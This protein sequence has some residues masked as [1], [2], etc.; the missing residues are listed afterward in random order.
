MSCPVVLPCT[1]GPLL[2]HVRGCDSPSVATWLHA[3]S[4]YTSAGVIW[5]N[6]A[7]HSRT[8]TAAAI[9]MHLQ[10]P[11]LD[12]QDVDERELRGV[13]AVGLLGTLEE[14]GWQLREK[15]LTL[16]AGE[17]DLDV[18]TAGVGAREAGAL[19]AILYHTEQLEREFDK[20]PAAGVAAALA[21]AAGAPQAV[22]KAR[23]AEARAALEVAEKADKPKH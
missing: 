10:V 7:T 12:D 14:V 6:V 19:T 23:A 16:W 2:H 21:A 4:P 1:D 15:L 9:A 3:P 13:V 8:Y 18:L 17:R 11:W 22:A 5:T 20:P